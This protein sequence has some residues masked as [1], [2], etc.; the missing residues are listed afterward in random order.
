MC[1]G[2]LIYREPDAV[3][4]QV[5]FCGGFGRSDLAILLTQD[6]YHFGGNVLLAQSYLRLG[7]VDDCE[8]VCEEYLAVAGYCFEFQELQAEARRQGAN[9]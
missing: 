7:L 1:W 5:R 6:P 8:R 4:P 2:T 3:V 9:T